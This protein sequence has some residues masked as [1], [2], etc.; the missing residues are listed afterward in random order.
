LR[1][2]FPVHSAQRNRLLVILFLVLTASLQLRAQGP[3]LGSSQD[4]AAEL[5]DSPGTVSS[6]LGADHDQAQP[7]PVSGNRAPSATP[8]TRLILPGEIAPSI[9]SGDKLAISVKENFSGY[10]VLGWL[11]SA[12]YSH[13]VDSQPNYGTDEGAFA[14]RLGASA[15]RGT[16]ENI[17]ADG[18]MASLLREDPRY[19]RLGRSHRVT[20]RVVYAVSRTVVTRTDGGRATAN[21]ALISGNL[22]GSALTNAYYPERNRS[23]SD[24]FETFGGSML[25]SAIGY[26]VDEF[27]GDLFSFM[28]HNK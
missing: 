14:Q 4:V 13:L 18:V 8:T 26:L 12:G 17:L 16:T 27:R 23:V 9:G 20:R 7:K 21:L 25:G 6:S 1:Y 15:L 3:P 10:A 2:E 5:P 19:Y 11:T 22:E 24:T 28:H